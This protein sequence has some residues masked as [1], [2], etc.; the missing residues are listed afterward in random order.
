MTEPGRGSGAPAGDHLDLDAL[1]DV[2]AG[3]RPDDAHLRRCAS[4][5]DR[6][7]ELQDAEVAVVASLATLPDP[8]LPDGLAARI[9]AALRAEPA[10]EA[11]PDEAQGVGTRTGTSTGTGTGTGTGT[12]TGTR[13]G[14]GGVTGTG[15][16]TGT[17]SV[18]RSPASVTTLPARRRTWLPAAAAAVALVLA[19][20]LAWPALQGAGS[21]ESADSTAAGG[22][23]A[24]TE[25]ADDAGAAQAAATVRNDSGTDYA[26]ETARAAALP[27]VLAG[28]AAP[29][30]VLES[31]PEATDEER[32][33]ATSSA[34]APDPL[35]RLRD[36][37]ALEDC[38][39]GLR[40]PGEGDTAPLALD[41]A[42][43]DGAP[44]LAVVLPGDAPD[45]LALFVVGA[46]CS[47]ADEQLLLFAR[48]DRP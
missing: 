26:D 12:R 35:A 14:T 48:P 3:E 24:E 13:A 6:L 40:A 27:Q 19:G 18:R 33:D 10:L 36:P 47:S 45:K 30:R 15:T 46:G 2:L 21:D 42:R 4:C 16:G 11:A 29:S 23:V 5:A 22:G 25:S 9:E 37:A 8:P 43:F 28:T 31:A 17:G 32:S 34:L 1:A 20:G 38:L 44:A 41:Y 39:S 7:A